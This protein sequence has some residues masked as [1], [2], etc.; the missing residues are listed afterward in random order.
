MSQY[1]R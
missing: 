1:W